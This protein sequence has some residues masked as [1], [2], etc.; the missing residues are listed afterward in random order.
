MFSD[1]SAPDEAQR[2]NR[3]SPLWAA[4]SRPLRKTKNICYDYLWFSCNDERRVEVVEVA[5][6]YC[7]ELC[8]KEE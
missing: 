6:K 2:R 8:P 3:R 4:F 1:C 5:T 7:V